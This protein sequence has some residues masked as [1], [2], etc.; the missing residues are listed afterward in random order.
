[1]RRGGFPLYSLCYQTVTCEGTSLALFSSTGR[2]RQLVF[3]F[4]RYPSF[5]AVVLGLILLN[6][7]LLAMDDATVAPDSTLRVL[8]DWADVAFASI[9]AAE[10]VTKL[11]ALGAWGCGDKYDA[12]AARACC[13]CVFSKTAML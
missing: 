13:A 1:M 7:V 8:L 2:F 3:A 5:E 11:V 10:M 9:F 4:V 6:C 12:H